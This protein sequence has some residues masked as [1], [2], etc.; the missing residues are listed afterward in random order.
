MYHI[1]MKQKLN[2][3]LRP[4]G[5]TK[6]EVLVYY[7]LLAYDHV[8]TTA[9]SREAKI[10]RT[11]LYTILATLEKRELAR[12]ITVGGHKEWQ[13]ASPEELQLIVSR[14][15]QAIEQAM[16]DLMQRQGYKTLHKKGTVEF[17][18][19]QKTKS[20]GALRTLYSNLRSLAKHEHVY[21]IEGVGSK[22]YKYGSYGVAY[23]K[24]WQRLLADAS[25]A[26]RVVVPRS[27]LSEMY[28]FEKSELKLFLQNPISLTVFDDEELDF[29]C[30]II[31]SKE[32]VF[33]A[34]PP[35]NTAAI[36]NYKYTADAM[37]NLFK[38]IEASGEKINFQEEVRNRL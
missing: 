1:H 6:S 8:N 7:K 9:L 32:Q 24:S 2:D 13:A 18:A 21:V 14:S 31:I 33:F 36:I 30:D 17:I 19:D 3:V 26:L 25:F 37:I 38:K 34:H 15:Y 22:Q 4:L 29:D 35:Y 23:K 27:S 28:A 12:Q 20:R 5:L 16:P 11:T 10:P